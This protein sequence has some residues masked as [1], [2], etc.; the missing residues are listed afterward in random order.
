M[1]PEL[2]LRDIHLPQAVSWWPPALGYWLLPL[3][4]VLLW[5]VVITVRSWLRRHS[6]K[7]VIKNQLTD[8]E[9]EYA[10]T[11]D[12]QLLVQKLSMLLRQVCLYYFPGSECAALTGENWLVF[13]DK[14]LSGSSAFQSGVGQSLISAPYQRQVNVDVPALLAL[15]KNWL[16]SVCGNT[17][18]TGAKHAA[19]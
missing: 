11:Q 7:K 13:L 12:A 18:H 8:L 19:V 9:A 14:Q 2:A 5:L 15:C 17:K 6:V 3:L 4:L 10:I 16:A 1:Q